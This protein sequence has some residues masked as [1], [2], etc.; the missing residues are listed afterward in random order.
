MVAFGSGVGVEAVLGVGIEEGE[1][2][3]VVSFGLESVCD[4]K[5]VVLVG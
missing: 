2:G 5:V 1:G 4:P 3:V